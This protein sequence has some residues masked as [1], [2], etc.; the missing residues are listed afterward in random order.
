MYGQDADVRIQLVH[1]TRRD[2]NDMELRA[3][4]RSRS[5]MRNG[6]HPPNLSRQQ[7]HVIRARPSR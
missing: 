7:T 5:R 4:H 2:D 3:V 6:D 1:A